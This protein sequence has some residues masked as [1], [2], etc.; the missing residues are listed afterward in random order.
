MSKKRAP[1]IVNMKKCEHDEFR[2][3][4][5]RIIKDPNSDTIY[6]KELIKCDL[7]GAKGSILY[8]IIKAG[9]QDGTNILEDL[10][11]LIKEEIK[12][13]MKK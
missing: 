2:S 9:F 7:C 13:E 10:P 8:Q 3:Y 1:R 6:M 12:E 5:H 11:N 4:K